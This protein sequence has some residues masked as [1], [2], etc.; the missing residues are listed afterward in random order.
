MTLPLRQEVMS[1][2]DNDMASR[3]GP[4]RGLRGM[5]AWPLGPTGGAGSYCPSI[6]RQGAESS[7]STFGQLTEHSIVILPTK[8]IPAGKALLTIGGEILRALRETTTVPRLWDKFR[9][10]RDTTQEVTFEWFV[11][12]LDLLYMLGAIELDRGRVRRSNTG[13]KDIS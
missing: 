11:L 6:G 13:S 4:A 2:S 8:G 7:A 3:L 5:M 9:K 12:G 1:L 10:S